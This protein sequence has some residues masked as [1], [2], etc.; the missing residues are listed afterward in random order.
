MEHY[1]T[2]NEV[3]FTYPMNNSWLSQ[4]TFILY[5][6]HIIILIARKRRLNTEDHT[7]LPS[8]SSKKNCPSIFSV[9]YD[10]EIQKE[11]SLHFSNQTN[12][13][14]P[15][16]PSQYNPH[17]CAR[18]NRHYNSILSSSYMNNSSEKHN[19]DINP[20]KTSNTMY[21][22]FYFDTYSC[23]PH[24]NNSICKNLMN[25]FD[26]VLS[27]K[28]DDADVSNEESCYPIYTP[29]NNQ[30]NCQNEDIMINQCDVDRFVLLHQNSALVRQYQS[31]KKEIDSIHH[32]D[33]NISSDLAR[34]DQLLSVSLQKIQDVFEFLKTF[35]IFMESSS[36][37]AH[38]RFLVI[39]YDPSKNLFKEFASLCKQSSSLKYD[40]NS[41]WN[42]FSNYYN[43]TFSNIDSLLERSSSDFTC[44]ET[45]KK[46]YIDELSQYKSTI[47]LFEQKFQEL[48]NENNTLKS[49]LYLYERDTSKLHSYEVIKNQIDIDKDIEI[50]K[51]KVEEQLKVSELK[52]DGI[53]IKKEG[54]MKMEI[55]NDHECVSKDENTIPNNKNT[56]SDT[57]GME[58]YSKEMLEKNKLVLQTREDTISQY[59][60]DIE[61][62]MTNNREYQQKI[63][64]L[65]S[66][67]QDLN[68]R[69]LDEQKRTETE[70]VTKLNFNLVQLDAQHKQLKSDYL[71]IQEEAKKQLA[72]IEEKYTKE[73]E[74]LKHENE[75]MDQ[76]L[77]NTRTKCDLY[78][79]KCWNRGVLY[80]QIKDYEIVVETLKKTISLH[81]AHSENGDDAQKIIA[82]ELN[83]LTKSLSFT[84][85][86][87]NINIY[88][89]ETTQKANEDNTVELY[90]FSC[91]IKNQKSKIEQMKKEREMMKKRITELEEQMEKELA[92]NKMI[93]DRYLSVFQLYQDYKEETMNRMK[94][95]EECEKK[96]DIYKQENDNLR[97]LLE[98]H[99]NEMKKL[100]ND[101]KRR[102]IE[103]EL[104][105]L[106]YKPK[107]ESNTDSDILL[108]ELNAYKHSLECDV[109]HF[110]PKTRIIKGCNHLFC[111]YCI[112]ERIARRERKCPSCLLPFGPNDI[113]RVHLLTDETLYDTWTCFQSKRKLA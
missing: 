109:C 81:A 8:I 62:L 26:E 34:K 44:Y 9:N 70:V 103:E 99:Y 19:R 105:I 1:N 72:I 54:E 43:K 98:N 77:R 38:I 29:L 83:S 15:Q 86:I 79:Q 108:K 53:S 71:S 39:I 48:I 76:E 25:D 45:L 28:Q 90:N 23:L 75:V 4:C 33:Q 12:S 55:E 13:T 88:Q 112:E 17:E 32:Q 58:L 65:E 110:Y 95:V 16:T 107:I 87:N 47:P 91:E 24:S 3:A 111:K 5:V 41:K 73:I 40:C 69:L 104:S 6:F 21:N 67:I 30:Q 51:K 18:T 80:R 35:V 78:K 94:K 37:Y 63:V 7:N 52:S 22:G 106:D 66:I 113:E 49:K 20:C 84:K 42:D 14:L 64:E 60:K 96:Y 59:E 56:N 50:E 100:F 31:I 2:R 85:D 93:T 46:Q 57:N 89:I 97:N 61:L 92:A 101:R 74:T 10:Q 82:Q 36:V 102:R 68:I 27:D 11:M